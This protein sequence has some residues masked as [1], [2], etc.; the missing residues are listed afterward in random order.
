MLC[1]DGE[2]M[3]CDTLHHPAEQPCEHAAAPDQHGRVILHVRVKG[4]THL[5]ACGF[6]GLV[7]AFWSSPG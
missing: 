7:Q 1:H 6:R 3:A 4:R 2:P 5:K